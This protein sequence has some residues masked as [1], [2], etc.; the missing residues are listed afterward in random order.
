MIQ[1]SDAAQTYLQELLT[2]QEQSGTGIRVFVAQ[3]GTPQAETC[4]AYCRPGEEQQ[5]DVPVEYEGFRAWFEERSQ[6][7]L[8]DAVVD[9]QE[10]QMGGQLTIKA[11]NARVPSVSEDSPLEDRINYVLYNEINPGLASHGGMVTL[12]E[13]TAENEAV[14]QFGGGCQGCS[15][16]DLTLKNSVESTL[17]ERLPELKGILDQTDHTFTENA[18]YS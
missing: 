17:M 3:P 11:P 10:D 7:Y 8:V 18:Y 4:I 12:V 1:I 9:Y 14:L 16:V 15:A 2:K 6:P 13:L 5:G